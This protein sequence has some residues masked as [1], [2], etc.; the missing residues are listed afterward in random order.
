MAPARWNRLAR[1]VAAVILIF[2]GI[3]QALPALPN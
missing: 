1:T 2:G 3:M